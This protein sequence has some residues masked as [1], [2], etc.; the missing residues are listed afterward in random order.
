MDDKEFLRCALGEG[1]DYDRFMDIVKLYYDSKIM[2]PSSSLLSDTDFLLRMFYIIFSRLKDIME[3]GS[4][5]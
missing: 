3:H 1:K 4:Q 2:D 5:K